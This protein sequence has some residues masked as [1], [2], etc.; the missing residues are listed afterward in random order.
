MRVI[1]HLR[2][3]PSF[4]VSGRVDADCLLTYLTKGQQHSDCPG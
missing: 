2:V 1:T 4:A 3:L